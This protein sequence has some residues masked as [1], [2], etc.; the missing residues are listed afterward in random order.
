[1]EKDNTSDKYS[2][3]GEE[4][5]EGGM[6]IVYLVTGLAIAAFTGIMVYF[7]LFA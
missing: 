6:V 3:D 7:T 4:L 2:P 1:M 5:A